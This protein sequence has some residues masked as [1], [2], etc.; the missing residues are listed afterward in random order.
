MYLPPS[1]RDVAVAALAQAI[2]IPLPQAHRLTGPV[3]AQQGLQSRKAGGGD[4]QREGGGEGEGA[5][6][7]VKHTPISH[8]W[9]TSETP[10]ST[11]TDGTHEESF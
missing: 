1:T 7:T 5:R 2:P 11:N 4:G 9:A 8:P 10:T 3:A 6:E